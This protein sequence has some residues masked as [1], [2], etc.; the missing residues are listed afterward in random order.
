MKSF[1]KTTLV[2]LILLLPSIALAYDFE[3]DGIYYSYRNGNE[4]KVDPAKQ[5]ART[6]TSGPVST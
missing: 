2:L 6:M 3:V 4:A 1:F 5:K